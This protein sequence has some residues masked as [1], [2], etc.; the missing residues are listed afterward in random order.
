M[1]LNE[2]IRPC[3]LLVGSIDSTRERAHGTTPTSRDFEAVTKPELG[4]KRSCTQCGAKFYDLNHSPITCPKCGAVSEIARVSSRP[5]TEAARASLKPVGAESSGVADAR[6]AAL[7]KKK[8]REASAV[9]HD[10]N[11]DIEGLGDVAFIEESED[12]DVSEIISGDIQSE[13]ET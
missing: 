13:K 4:T 5:R 11:L 3:R 2:L 6:A 12:T 1:A 7:R 9:E 10:A 8:P